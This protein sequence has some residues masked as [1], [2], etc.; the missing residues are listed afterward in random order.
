WMS[1]LI[2]NNTNQFLIAAVFFGVPF[3]LTQF[4]SNLAIVAIFAPLVA[5]AS[6]NL[7]LDPRAAVLAAVTASSCSFL[8]PLASPAQTMIMEPG[9]YN[10]WNYIKAG[11][12]LAVIIMVLGSLIPLIYPMN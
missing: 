6:V 4:M 9:G 11:F 8:T 5:T 1:T 3:I 2:G 7:G 12:P 10:L